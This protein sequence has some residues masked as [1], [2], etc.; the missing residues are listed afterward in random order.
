MSD[1]VHVVGFGR[2]CSTQTFDLKNAKNVSALDT[3]WFNAFKG[4]Q[5]TY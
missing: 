5:Q 4:N 3:E 1:I 2:Y